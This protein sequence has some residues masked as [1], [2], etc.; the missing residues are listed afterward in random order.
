M[1]GGD[2]AP[3]SEMAIDHHPLGVN[4]HFT[5]G[6]LGSTSEMAM[7]HHPLGVNCHFTI[8]RKRVIDLRQSDPFGP[9][10]A[11]HMGNRRQ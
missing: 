6:R 8:R 1:I 3:H 9:L 10:R 11:V 5:I 7:D 4:C 2:A